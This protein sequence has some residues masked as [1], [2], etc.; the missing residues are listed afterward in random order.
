ML[1]LS[2]FSCLLAILVFYKGY[3]WSTCL[4]YLLL[5]VVYLFQFNMSFSIFLSMK[6]LLSFL[7]FLF[8]IIYY[9]DDIKKLKMTTW[10]NPC[11]AIIGIG[12]DAS[13]YSIGTP[14]ST[15]VDRSFHLIPSKHPLT[16]D[17]LRSKMFFAPCIG[18]SI[19]LTDDND[20]VLQERLQTCGKCQDWATVSIY[21][22]SCHKYLSYSC[23]NLFRSL[24]M[25]QIVS[26]SLLKVFDHLVW[27]SIQQSLQEVIEF[28]L[29]KEAQEF[30]IV[31]HIPMVEFAVIC[32]HVTLILF[33]MGFVA[34]DIVNLKEE[35]LED[36]DEVVKKCFNLHVFY[37]ETLKLIL[38]LVLVYSWHF[39]V[40][41]AV[42]EYDFLVYVLTCLIVG[43]IINFIVS[44]KFQPIKND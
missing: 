34:F 42:M 17:Q 5:A 12:N 18:F 27:K 39:Y 44:R 19:S 29:P 23:I 11:H 8:E 22:L 37:F 38:L 14:T 35:R 1:L 25:I 40:P 13:H 26:F 4:E 28:G 33:H 41:C 43:R 3:Q 6:V 10:N 36:N 20:N 16:T 15:A 9:S 21:L 31:S 32:L 30:L 7:T 2:F 24:T